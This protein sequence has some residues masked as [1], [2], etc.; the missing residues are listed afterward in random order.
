MKRRNKEEKKGRTLC[1]TSI[2]K[3]LL[4]A[5]RCKLAAC[6]KETA[7]RIMVNFI[8]K[9]LNRL[10]QLAVADFQF[11]EFAILKHYT[12]NAQTSLQNKT[13]KSLS[14]TASI[15]GRIFR[16]R[17]NF[18]NGRWISMR[19]WTVYFSTSSIK[20][21]PGYYN[22]LVSKR[23]GNINRRKKKELTSS[24]TWLVKDRF[25]PAQGLNRL[26]YQRKLINND[27]FYEKNTCIGSND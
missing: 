7:W 22:V 25:H 19:H 15:N 3:I 24:Q 17:R 16:Y 5:T 4:R 9:H 18:I 10:K 2:R 12:L 8:S 11:I 6:A 23:R 27:F 21:M 13:L 1:Q 20:A 14:T 26:C